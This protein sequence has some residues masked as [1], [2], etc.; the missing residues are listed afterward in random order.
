M[1]FIKEKLK[2][3]QLKRQVYHQQ[4]LKKEMFIVSFV[5]Y[6]SSGKTSLFN[7]L[8]NE[9]KETSSYLFTTLSTTTRS[10]NIL[11]S[12]GEIKM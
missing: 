1:S 9:N 10:L 4:R 5:G 3:A 12:I 8:T 11:N 2:D 7:L 6:T